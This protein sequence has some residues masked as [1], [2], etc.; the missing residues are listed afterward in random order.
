MG[1]WAG[2]WAVWRMV[3]LGHH[4]QITTILYV[5]FISV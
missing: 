3:K 4:H 2:V 5:K 1:V